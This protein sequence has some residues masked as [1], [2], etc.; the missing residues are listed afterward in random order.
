MYST[1]ISVIDPS[2]LCLLWEDGREEKQQLR[3]FS[4]R[5]MSSFIFSAVHDSCITDCFL[6][7]AITELGP[8]F[9][10]LKLILKQFELGG[11]SRMER[12]LDLLMTL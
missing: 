12:P 10:V 7:S 11:S 1:I 6:F 4:V 3:P 5:P 2:P 9:L 8:F